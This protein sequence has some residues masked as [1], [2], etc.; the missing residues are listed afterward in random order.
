MHPTPANADRH[1]ATTSPQVAPSAPARAMP[2]ITLGSVGACT[3]CAPTVVAA[4]AAHKTNRNI[5]AV[6]IRIVGRIAPR[7]GCRIYGVKPRCLSQRP[8]LFSR[9][10]RAS[11]FKAFAR[12]LF[13]NYSNTHEWV[14]FS[15][16]F[17]LTCSYL[18]ANLTSRPS[19]SHHAS[20]PK[21]E[22]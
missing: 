20:L 3:C 22:L 14:N 12:R 16:T 17:P 9:R 7:F 13:H 1:Y 5:K 6:L 19:R 4:S 2:R 8:I 10:L 18:Y 11:A 21:M 15:R